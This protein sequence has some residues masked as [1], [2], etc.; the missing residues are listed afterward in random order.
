MA[1]PEPDT[2]TVDWVSGLTRRQATLTEPQIVMVAD[3]LSGKNKTVL[4]KHGTNVSEVYEFLRRQKQIPAKLD[5]NNPDEY[6]KWLRKKLIDPEFV[7]LISPIL[8]KLEFN[9]GGL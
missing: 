5:A 9:F 6:K 8:R 3:W 7:M 4:E 2:D 1:D